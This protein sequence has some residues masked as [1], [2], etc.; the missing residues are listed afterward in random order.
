[1]GFDQNSNRPLVNFRRWTS[2]VNLWLVLGVLVFFG[3]GA[4]AIVYW[5]RTEAAHEPT[6]AVESGRWH[7]TT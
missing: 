3:L 5:V 4:F 7:R 1:M 6:S 2:K